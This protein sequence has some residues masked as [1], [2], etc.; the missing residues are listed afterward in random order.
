MTF[1][2]T[3]TIFANLKLTENSIFFYVF[4]RFLC[5]FRRF[6]CK[7]FF[8]KKTWKNITKK[9]SKNCRRRDSNH[10]PYASLPDAIPLHHGS[11]VGQIE[12]KTLLKLT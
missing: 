2:A 6:A 1:S 10:R 12:N 11:V 9:N 8:A 4:S 3:Y 5:I 7:T